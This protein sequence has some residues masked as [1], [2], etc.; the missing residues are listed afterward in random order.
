M[1]QKQQQ[2][3]E[4]QVGAFVGVGVILLMLVLF[5]LG[6]ENRMFETNYTLNAHFENI[7]GLRVGAGVQ[8]AGIHVGTVK[9]IIFED[10][11]SQKKVK[12]VLQV[13]SNYKDRI[14]Q[15]S[16]ASIQTQGL[17]GDKMVWISVGSSDK[18]TLEDGEE[19]LVRKSAGLDALMEK[20]DSMASI[21]DNVNNLTKNLNEMIL[22]IKDGKGFANELIYGTQGKEMMKQITEVAANLKDTTQNVGDITQ[23]INEGQGTLGAIVNDASLF[24]DIK[25]LLGKANR[26]KLIRAVIRETMRTRDE[27]LL[28]TKNTPQKGN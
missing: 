22:E 14:R 23:K 21:V 20:G 10:N 4:L 12:L 28:E 16:V 18:P 13:L 8:L 1:S 6:S 5:M 9:K 24:N 2:N 15:D 19:L 17:L 26:N 27:E 3:M 11:L 25:T 7:S